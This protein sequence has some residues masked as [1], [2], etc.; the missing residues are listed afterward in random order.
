MR[1]KGSDTMRQNGDHLRVVYSKLRKCV[2]LYLK[3]S[4]MSSMHDPEIDCQGTIIAKGG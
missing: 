2:T 4:L 1:R 3:I